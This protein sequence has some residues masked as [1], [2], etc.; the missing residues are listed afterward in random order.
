[1]LLYESYSHKGMILGF[2][3]SEVRPMAMALRGLADQSRASYVLMKDILDAFGGRVDAVQLIGDLNGGPLEMN[4]KLR[5]GRSTH[6]LMVG[7]AEGI[8]IALE[9]PAPMYIS[10]EMLRR[11]GFELPADY[12]GSFSK[13]KGIESI[14]RK[15]RE[16]QR[17]YETRLQELNSRA[18]GKTDSAY[19]IS[20]KKVFDYLYS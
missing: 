5:K 14:V 8:G 9:M 2:H 16:D 4:V 13:E 11:F 7:P 18:A 20:S 6:N 19:A 10:N 12:R 1:M 17:N 15:V 3:D